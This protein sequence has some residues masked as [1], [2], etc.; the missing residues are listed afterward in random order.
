MP[1]LSVLVIDDEVSIR[2][3]LARYFEDAGARVLTVGT[4]AD[5]RG[6]AAREVFDL[7]FL[8]LRLG[9][10]SGL[11]LL[12]DLRR[13]QPDAS[14]VVVTAYASIET[15]VE[16]MRR[17]ASDYLPKPFTPSQVA[18]TVERT[19]RERDARR[20]LAAARADRD[21]G[22]DD[23]LESRSPAMQPV[24]ALARAAAASEATLLLSGPSGTGKSRLA[25]AVHRWSAR[26]EGMFVTVSAPASTPDLIDADLFGHTR[27]A[28]TGATADSPGRV[29]LAEGGTLFLDEIGEMPLA[30]QPKLLRLLQERAYERVGD[31][32]ER[33]ADVR[34]VAATNRDLRAEV[35]AGRFREDLYYRLAVVEVELPPLRARA[36]DL[37]A[38]AAT[39]LDGLARRYNRPGLALTDGALAALA[40]HEWPGNLRELGN[41]LERAVILTTGLEIDAAALQIGRAGA[42]PAAGPGA[43]PQAGDPITLAALDEAHLRAVLARSRSYDEAAT[44]LGIDQATLWRRRKAFGV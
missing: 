25:R 2:R 20:A 8:D 31:P 12:P 16:A 3:V 19:R 21:G 5:A 17:G 35:A 42:A 22:A 15:A 43:V 34:V 44:T 28:Y 27:G 18:L 14:I 37:P 11:D 29:G 33:R 32:R 6:E 24:L 40:A 36:D 26:A 10:A 1:P 7:V 4:A 38:L 9:A 41:A 30:L 13:H 39:L 23:L